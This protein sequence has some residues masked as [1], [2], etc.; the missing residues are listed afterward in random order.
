MTATQ[1]YVLRFGLM[2]KQSDCFEKNWAYLMFK[3]FATPVHLLT[4]SK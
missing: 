4:E 1:Y 3:A 2:C